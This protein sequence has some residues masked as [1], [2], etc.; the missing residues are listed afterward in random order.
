MLRSIFSCIALV[1]SLTFFLIHSIDAS[2]KNIDWRG[3]WNHDIEVTGGVGYS[4]M[5]QTPNRQLVISQDLNDELQPGHPAGDVM[6]N[7]AVKKIMALHNNRLFKSIAIGPAYY[8]QHTTFSGEV[9][10][11]GLREFDNYHYKLTSDISSLLL[12]SD[13]LMTPLYHN[14]MPFLSVGLGVAIAEVQ[15]DDYANSGISTASELHLNSR[16]NINAAFGVGAG[17]NF[18]VNADWCLSLRYIYLYAGNVDTATAGLNA[19]Q[20]P[21]KANLNSQ[22]LVLSAIYLH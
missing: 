11:L 14:V 22:A 7:L 17:L 15:Y 8:Y 1:S 13:I 4:R 16:Y 19:P 6:L 5:I 20:A 18:P 2:A 10:E 9:W 12:E 3:Y 21:I